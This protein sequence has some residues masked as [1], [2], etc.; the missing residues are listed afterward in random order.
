MR[1]VLFLGWLILKHMPAVLACFAL[2]R[3]EVGFS[4]GVFVD[5]ALVVQ[6]KSFTRHQKNFNAHRQD[7]SEAAV[8]E[9]DCTYSEV[10]AIDKFVQDERNP[11]ARG[12]SRPQDGYDQARRTRK[13]TSYTQGREKAC[14]GAEA[15]ENESGVVRGVLGRRES[16][17]EPAQEVKTLAQDPRV[18]RSQPVQQG[19]SAGTHR[20]TDSEGHRVQLLHRDVLLVANIQ[21]S[22]FHTQIRRKEA[23]HG[24]PQTQVRESL[25]LEHHRRQGCPAIE[26][27][28]RC[29]ANEDVESQHDVS[30]QP[31]RSLLSCSRQVA[32]W[33]KTLQPRETPG[34]TPTTLLFFFFLFAA[35]SFLLFP[36]VEQRGGRG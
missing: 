31:Q 3:K 7:R 4:V 10:I 30:I 6:S 1:S 18:E 32:S 16:E 25:R 13:E 28:T 36:A 17:Q 24:V 23:C 2:G 29:E 15:D 14:I 8:D 20:T 19:P 35:S 21:L 9:R 5:F 12:S 11:E 26:D 34:T 33:Q 27:R 22:L